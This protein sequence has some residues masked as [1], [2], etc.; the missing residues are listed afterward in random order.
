MQAG[1]WAQARASAAA[2]PDPVA[3]ELVQYLRILNAVDG[4]ER[5]SAVE[6]ATF[7]DKHPGWP[8]QALLGRRLADAI[9]DAPDLRDVLALC[10]SHP[11]DAPAALAR[12]AEA[13][14]W[15]GNTDLAS[16]SAKAAWTGGLV[17][18]EDDFLA[19]WGA[20]LTQ[21]DQ[22]RR[23]ERLVG[24]DEAAGRQLARLGPLHRVAAQ[25]RLAFRHDDPG[26]LT[27]LAFVAPALRNDPALLLDEAR[28]LRRTQAV[29]AALALWQGAGFAAETR[30][31]PAAR[32]AFWAERDIL[33]RKELAQGDAAAALALADDQALQAEQAVD[34]R[35]LAG[36]ILLRRLHDPARAAFRFADLAASSHSAITLARA[37]YWLARAAA[38]QGAPRLAAE[39]YAKAAAWPTTFYG[40]QAEA[41]LGQDSAA[42]IAALRDPALDPERERAIAGQ[43]LARAASKLVEWGDGRRARSFVLRLAQDDPSAENFTACAALA[44]HL[45]L[46]ET[47]VAIARLAGHDG[48]VLP[49]RGWPSPFEPPAGEAGPDL[50]LGVMR[51]ESSFDPQIVSPV[52]AI[53]LM[54]MMP[55]TALQ[56]SRE[57]GAGPPPDLRDPQTNMRLGTRTL[58]A[59]LHQFGG[60]VPYA[61]AAYDA[62]PRRVRDWIAVNGDISGKD[63]EAVIDWIELIPFNETRNYVQRVMENAAIYHA[64]RTAER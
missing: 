31:A 13:Q 16:A 32:Q 60:V 57:D 52:G 8:G 3:A 54:Q 43:E 44:L 41:A 11:P 28:S 27:A 49:R 63:Q 40:Q 38:A 1:D 7:I 22:W 64:R 35:F 30:S 23:F 2:D 25:A 19:R 61:L 5:P 39:E 12:C 20:V 48:V 6:V 58:D 37:H 36:W 10:A 45:G 4:A 55:R 42:Q 21:E 34:A 9:A 46:P 53:G 14:G 51:Q 33:A 26:A 17:Q 59:L 15:A 62:G 50:A 24:N 18:G 47:A 56:M 29:A